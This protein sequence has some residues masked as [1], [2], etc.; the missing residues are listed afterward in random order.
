MVKIFSS[1][2]AA[3]GKQLK[4]SVNVFQSLMLYRRLP[5]PS[6]SKKKHQSKQ[7]RQNQLQSPEGAKHEIK[8]RTFVVEAINTIYTCT[9]VVAP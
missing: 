4:Q 2:I 1:I 3:I 5:I 6:E 9:L 7:Y 8:G